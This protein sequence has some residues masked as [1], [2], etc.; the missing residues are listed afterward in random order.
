[1]E[2]DLVP[3]DPAPFI[4][5][6]LPLKV[7]SRADGTVIAEID[8]TADHLNKAK[9][10]HGG[11]VAAVLDVAVATAA[12]RAHEGEGRGYGLTMSLTINYLSAAQ[13]GLARIKAWVTGGGRA[14]KF[15]NAELVDSTGVLVATA[16]STLKV[17]AFPTD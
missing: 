8:F 11:A 7:G 1:M 16:T 4:A 10:V 15:V 14:T 9:V 3:V 12:S 2:A 6:H 5:Q 17:V 13:A